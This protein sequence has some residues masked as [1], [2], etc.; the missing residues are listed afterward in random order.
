MNRSIHDPIH[1][2]PHLLQPTRKNLSCSMDYLRVSVNRPLFFSVI[3]FSFTT[4][5][6]SPSI[7]SEKS[8]LRGKLL[9]ML[10]KTNS[11]SLNS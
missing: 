1:P 9:E 10:P 4:H 11:S 8:F 6:L 7:K 2:H 5:T 3:A